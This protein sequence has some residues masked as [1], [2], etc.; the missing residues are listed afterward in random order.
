VSSGS[1][2]LPFSA[3]LAVKARAGASS[4]GELQL[5]SAEMVD[6]RPHS[7]SKCSSTCTTPTAAQWLSGSAAAQQWLGADQ[8]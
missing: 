4:S 2:W 3:S 1:T 7:A 6:T 8:P 5:L